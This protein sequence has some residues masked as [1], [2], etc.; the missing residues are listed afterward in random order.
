[1]MSGFVESPLM[2]GAGQQFLGGKTASDSST[3]PAGRPVVKGEPGA[4]VSAP[5]ASMLNDPIDELRSPFAVKS[6]CPAASVAIPAAWPVPSENGEPATE[7]RAPLE[8]T[9]N[10]STVWLNWLL[11]KSFVS[12]GLSTPTLELTP[13]P[14]NGEPPIGARTP[15]GSM[16]K[17]AIWAFVL[18]A[19]LA[20]R[21]FSAQLQSTLAT[22]SKEG[23]GGPANGEPVTADNV[24]VVRLMANM[25]ILL[26]VPRPFKVTAR[27]FPF[28][29]VV[30]IPIGCPP[31][32]IGNP[33]IG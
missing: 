24:P 8:S 30:V 33:G 12:S 9:L 23:S 15:V 5:L 32:S 14:M 17:T 18:F 19:M 13:G 20:N 27:N 6:H 3:A 16:L 22:E 21:R 7:V 2:T 31:A 26:T 10:A 4:A 25:A 1:M 11:T 28:T 29:G